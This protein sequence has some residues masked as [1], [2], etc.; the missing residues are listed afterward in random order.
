VEGRLIRRL[1]HSPA[2]LARGGRNEV[3]RT[4]SGPWVILAYFTSDLATFERE[5][6]EYARR[7][8]R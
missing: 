6:L 4:R 2:V 7:V 8:A 3:L 5:Y 1:L